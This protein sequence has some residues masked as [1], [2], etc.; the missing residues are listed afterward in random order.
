[1]MLITITQCLLILTTH[2]IISWGMDIFKQKKI[3]AIAVV[4]LIITALALTLTTAAIL[5]SNQTAPLNGTLSAVNLGIFSDSAC[6]QAATVLNVGTLSPG[7]TAT[8][9]VYIKNTGNVPETLTMTTNNWTPNSASS[10]LTL[11][12]NHQNTVLNAEQSIQATITLTVASNT[13]SLTTFSCD[14]TITGTQ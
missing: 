13:D 1:M 11:T 12:W 14:V 3:P 5:S 9:I 6:T 2:D 8:Q 4:A 10:Y 7:R